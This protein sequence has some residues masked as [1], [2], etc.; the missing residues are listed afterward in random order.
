MLF[1]YYHHYFTLNFT[2]IICQRYYTCAKYMENK[3]VEVTRATGCA[4]REVGSEA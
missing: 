1:Y 3:V 4:Q 2:I